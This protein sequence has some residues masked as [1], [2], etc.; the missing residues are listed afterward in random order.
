MLYCGFF[1]KHLDL[2]LIIEL[3]GGY[4]EDENQK[5]YDKY[6][7]EWLIKNRECKV[8]RFTNDQV[9]DDY[10]FIINKIIENIS[11]SKEKIKKHFISNRTIKKNE[12]KIKL[13]KRENERKSKNKENGK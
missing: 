3:D 9:F 4:H 10:N 6:R 12:R 11:S 7:E 2:K 5:K 1:I 8:L 13:L